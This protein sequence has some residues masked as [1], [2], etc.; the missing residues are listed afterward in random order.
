[1]NRKLIAGAAFILSSVVCY[2]VKKRADKQYLEQK[3]A[4]MVQ[5]AKTKSDIL[6]YEDALTAI[7]LHDKLV[8]QEKKTLTEQFAAWKKEKKIDQKK[9][10]LYSQ[11]SRAIEDFKKTF[12]YTEAIEELKKRK[13]ESLDAFKISVDYD[14]KIE[15]LQ[16]AIEQADHKWEQQK[17]MFELADDDIS[18]TAS[19]LRHA[20]EDARDAAVKQAKAKIK[21]LED[22]LAAETAEWDKKIQKTTREYEEKIAREKTR[23]HDKVQN[24]LNSI[25]QE[26]DQAYRDISDQIRDSRTE[27]ESDAMAFYEDNKHLVKTQDEIDQLAALDIFQNTP[28]PER[29]AWWFTE[30]KWPKWTVALVGFL[31]ALAANYLITEYTNFL[32]KVMKAM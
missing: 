9:K 25:D 1:M 13:N 29:L 24:G 6:A 4:D 5:E 3:A 17:A 31:P 12:G 26:C 22:K 16:D 7:D 18:E 14:S 30:H 21:E 28:L 20:A 15:E 32:V 10:E 23:L 2:V 8:A 19:K 27:V 11:E